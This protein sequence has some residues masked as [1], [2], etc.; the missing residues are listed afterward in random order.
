MKEKEN[1]AGYGSLLVSPA[2]CISR[3]PYFSD[4]PEIWDVWIHDNFLRKGFGKAVLL[5]R[6][7]VARKAGYKQVGIEV[8]LYADYGPAQRLYSSLVYTPDEH[9]I[10]LHAKPIARQCH[11]VDDDLHWWLKKAL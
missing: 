6:E 3:N 2:L 11:L 4:A 10:S 1:I 5:Y 8:G 9:A 7:D